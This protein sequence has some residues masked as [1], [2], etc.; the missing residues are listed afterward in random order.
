MCEQ[1]RRVGFHCSGHADYAEEGYDILCSAVSA[2]TQTAL[3]GIVEVAGV[4]AGYAINDGD[5]HCVLDRDAT[6]QQCRDA[7]LLLKTLEAGL[8]SIDKSY[9]GYLKI[10]SEEV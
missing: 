1:G 9:P 10:L 5:L 3:Q 8:R 7:D 4:P 6:E 2:L